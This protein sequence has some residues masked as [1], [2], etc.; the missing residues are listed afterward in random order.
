MLNDVSTIRIV[1]EAYLPFSLQSWAFWKAHVSNPFTMCYAVCQN[2]TQMFRQRPF[3]W[4]T[5][6]T[7][8]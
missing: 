1:I 7:P 4:R 6:Q 2:A 8:G 3:V 5:M